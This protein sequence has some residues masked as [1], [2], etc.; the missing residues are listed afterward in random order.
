MEF[1]NR[2]YLIKNQ[3]Y[4]LLLLSTLTACG[5]DTPLQFSDTG[6]EGAVVTQ[7]RISDTG[8]VTVNGRSF[9]TTGAII[10][11]NDEPANG[12]SLRTGMQVTVTSQSSTATQIRYEEEVKGPVDFVDVNGNLIVMGQDVLITNNTLIDDSIPDLFAVGNIV[13]ISGIRDA[14]HIIHAT[15]VEGKRTPPNAYEVRGTVTHLNRDNQIFQIGNLLISYANARFD[16]FTVASLSNGDMVEVKDELR[17]YEPGSLFLRATKIESDRISVNTTGQSPGSMP[18]LSG[19]NNRIEVEIEAYVTEIISDTRFKIGAVTVNIMP[20]TRFRDGD[21]S[22]LQRNVR[23]EVEGW[24][25]E[26]G[27]LEAWE[28]EFDDDQ[29]G[30]YNSDDGE[31]FLT[32]DSSDTSDNND[33]AEVKLEGIV[34][35]INSTNGS[36]SI[37][38]VQVQ[39]GNRTEY[40]NGNDQSISRNQFFELL[41]DGVTVVKVKWKQFVSYNESPHEVEIEI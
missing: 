20:H 19:S 17:Q 40:E 37:N 30:Y 21:R 41:I 33:G 6:V 9:S 38:G 13:E 25:N 27:I 29:S 35:S 28:I 23:I 39:T 8:N 36:F 10:L 14:D 31:F 5:S 12:S 11:M 34:S 32:D 16:D 4:S 22:Q 3:F 2:N 1:K 18:Q 24:L 15:F 26:D 7:G